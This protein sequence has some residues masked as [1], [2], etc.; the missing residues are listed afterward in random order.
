MKN[1]RRLA[2]ASL[3]ALMLLAPASVLATRRAT[4]TGY[5]NC[6]ACNNCRYCKHCAKNGGTCGVCRRQRQ[7][8]TWEGAKQR[9]EAHSH[10]L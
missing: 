10:S 9:A 4:C 2:L 1:V 6:R 3:T 5:A 8:R 7:A